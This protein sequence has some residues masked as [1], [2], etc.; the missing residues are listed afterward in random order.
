[1]RGLTIGEL[2][3]AANVPVSTIRFY[4]R[5]GI[6]AP[7]A[8]TGANYREYSQQAL[9]RLRFIRASQST[10]FSIAD[11]RKLLDLT[12]SSDPPCGEV[13]DLAKN[14]LA[15]VR[16][17]LADLKRVE[18]ALARS[19]EQC[20]KGEGDDLCDEISRMRGDRKLYARCSAE[21][22]PVA[23]TLNRS[24]TSRVR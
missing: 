13:I 6:L 22:R 5:N 8:R 3:K 15:D 18:K 11:I 19:L 9:E 17:R 24:S 21:K 23:L 16:Q 12:F 1:M 7:D 10:G 4:E 20:C 14:R 2:A